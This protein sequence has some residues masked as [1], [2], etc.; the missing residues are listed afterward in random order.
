M[1]PYAV[2]AVPSRVLPVVLLVGV[3]IALAAPGSASAQLP[4]N[5]N[6]TA[7]R[8]DR[9]IGDGI[10][11]TAAGTCTL[12]AAIQEANALLGHDTINV[13]P[14]TYELEIP[15]VNYDVP[16]TG[17]H[18][19]ADS[20]SIVGTGAGATIIDGGFPIAGAPVEARG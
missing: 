13:P 1:R 14:G 18:D 4:L 3:F 7:D 20:V 9:S 15:S 6:N 5:V 2:R 12:R 17:D 8:P 10:C 11:A 19:I 16:S